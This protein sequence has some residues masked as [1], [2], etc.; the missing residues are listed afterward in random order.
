MSFALRLKLENSHQTAIKELIQ[1]VREENSKSIDKILEQG[2]SLAWR[3]IHQDKESTLTPTT[4]LGSAL[5]YQK[6]HQ[7]NMLWEKCEK[8]QLHQA[9]KVQ[10]DI[11]GYSLL[12]WAISSGELSI[13]KS[14]ILKTGDLL[15]FSKK[16]AEKLNN[17]PTQ[18]GN[19]LLLA[20]QAWLAYVDP[21]EKNLPS[22]E[23]EVNDK[24]I[25]LRVLIFQ[26]N[27][28]TKLTRL[29]KY[30]QNEL[31]NLIQ[32]L[33]ALKPAIMKSCNTIASFVDITLECAT[34]R[35]KTLETAPRYQNKP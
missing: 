10:M 5:F 33:T 18:K 27:E 4:A 15:D 24:R 31:Q 30:Q 22:Y 16:F 25:D 20:Y 35:A 14:L 13:L 3:L 2:V 34:A 12:F 8:S 23:F 9:A 17:V 29:D 28:L 21:T 32:S 1:A 7:F 26:I 19:Q 11:Q 6:T